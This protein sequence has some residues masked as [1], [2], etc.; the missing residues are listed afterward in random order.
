MSLK[1]FWAVFLCR[2]LE[3]L[4]DR[5]TLLWNLV[6]PISLIAGFAF[7]FSGTMLN[8]YKVGVLGDKNTWKGDFFTI[9][10]IRFIP[11]AQQPAAL[12]KIERHQLDML[13]DPVNRQYWINDES[14]KGYVLERL[15][16]GTHTNTD[17]NA[18]FH[19]EIISGRIIR[20]VDWV[21][22]GVLAMNTMFS[23]L[24]GVG[25]VIVRYRKTGTLRRLKVTPL[26]P[27]EFLA[28]Q[29]A[30]R[31]WLVIATAVLVFVSTDQIINFHMHGAYLDLLIVLA[32]GS[33]SLISLSLIVAARVKSEEVAT[34]L[35]NFISW[36]M[37]F[38]SGVWFSLEG[39]NPFLQKCAQLAPLTHM[40]DAARAIMIDGAGLADVSGH[41]LALAIM[42]AIFMAIGVRLFRWE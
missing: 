14:A 38:L 12:V 41:L 19:K 4:R 36:P 13:L 7:A 3:F 15:L 32:T 11:I 22:P 40:I 2:N 34:G 29:I 28:A 30:S 37:T 16:R 25:H 21:L 42:S 20:Y 23:C 18:G 5:S 6:F 8:T 10:Y 24:F 1:R 27:L 17:T 26:T 35:L 39:V 31:L 33:I 9:R